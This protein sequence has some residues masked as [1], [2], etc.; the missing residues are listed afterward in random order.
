MKR[1]TNLT[2]KPKLFISELERP[3]AAAKG[4]KVTTLAVGE[5]TWWKGDV[6][7]MAVGEEA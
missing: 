4:G 1:L 7:T 3:A 2:K 6:T 5:E